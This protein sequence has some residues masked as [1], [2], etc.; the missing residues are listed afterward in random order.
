MVLEQILPSNWFQKRSWY[1]F[2]LS[3]GYS[4]LAIL[5][6]RFIFA[7]NAGIVSVF[8]ITLFL[9]PTM[10]KMFLYE[11]LIE[12]KET[13][14]SFKHLIRNNACLIKT[15]LI[16][17]LNKN[18]DLFTQNQHMFSKEIHSL[19]IF[20]YTLNSIFIPFYDFFCIIL[21][22]THRNIITV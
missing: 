20:I 2:L 3:I 18:K 11:N 13:Y 7:S 6:A 17:F 14:F 16:I 5:I 22:Q 4:I 19:R 9:L 1:A 21:T 8:F 15:Y 10:K 12:E